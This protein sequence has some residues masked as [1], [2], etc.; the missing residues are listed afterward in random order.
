MKKLAG[1]EIIEEVSS[2]K[3]VGL[4]MIFKGNKAD[5]FQ[6]ISIMDNDSV[7]TLGET[8]K[9]QVAEEDYSTVNS[10]SMLMGGVM[11]DKIPN[12]EDGDEF[13]EVY[14]CYPMN[15]Y[16]EVRIFIKQPIM[17]E[18]RVKF[19]NNLPETPNWLGTEWQD[20]LNIAI[21]QGHKEITT[22]D[23]SS[24]KIINDGKVQSIP[25]D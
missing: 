4:N 25:N 1:Y 6:L 10:L 9:Q 23:G 11:K 16:D 3:D 5:G 13:R 22:P 2:I 21:N 8:M 24:Y 18:V 7:A 12:Y 17:E 14:L 15:G 19:K 20:E